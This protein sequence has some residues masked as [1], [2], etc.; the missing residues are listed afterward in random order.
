MKKFYSM[1]IA[2]TI[3]L[4]SL[5]AF[6]SCKKGDDDPLLFIW[7]TI[8]DCFDI[9]WT[10]PKYEKNG[11]VRN[12]IG[13][14]YTFPVKNDCTLTQTIEGSIFGFATKTNREDT[15]SFQNDDENVK[16]TISRSVVIYNIQRLASKKL[17]LKNIEG[18]IKHICYFEGL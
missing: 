11:T 5:F 9:T 2:L 3:S 10:L 8:R 15:W 17:W 18:S 1:L 16:I 14:T 4:T 6:T 13:T 12:I 7:K